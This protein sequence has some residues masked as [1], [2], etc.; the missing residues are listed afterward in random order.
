MCSKPSSTSILCAYNKQRLS[1][2]CA[3]A[4]ARTE[5]VLFDYA[6]RTRGHYANGFFFKLLKSSTGGT[7]GLK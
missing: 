1:R 4:Q 3:Y 6:I 7:S 5:S 2:S